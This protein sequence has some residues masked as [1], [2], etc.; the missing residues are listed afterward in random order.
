MM[1]Y[2]YVYYYYY[3]FYPGTQFPGNE[4]N[5]LPNAKKVQKS[6]WNEPY[7][8]S[9]MCHVILATPTWGTVSHQKA[10]TSRGQLDR[11]QNLKSLAAAVAEIF[12]G[13]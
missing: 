3:Y 10:N 7:S 11:V 2:K 12:Q 6:S 8:A 9:K 13:V 1:L 4:K 5:T